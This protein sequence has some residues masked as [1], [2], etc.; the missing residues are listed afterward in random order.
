MISSSIATTRTTPSKSG[1]TSSP[2]AFKVSPIFSAASVDF[3]LMVSF[4]VKYQKNAGV[5][6]VV[7]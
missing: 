2:A 3:A 6:R 7:A 4:A 5:E 1:R